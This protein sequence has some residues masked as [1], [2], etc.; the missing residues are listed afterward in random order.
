MKLLPPYLLLLPYVM[1]SFVTIATLVGAWY[2][3]LQADLLG[4]R[5]GLRFAD[6]GYQWGI[7]NDWK[8]DMASGEPS[9]AM[10]NRLKL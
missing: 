10:Q 2:D 9:I 8:N 4:T 3:W 1:S 6:P 7:V 5:A